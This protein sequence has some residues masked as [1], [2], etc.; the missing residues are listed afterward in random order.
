M[1]V[2]SELAKASSKTSLWLAEH[3]DLSK[4][5]A[6]LL[7]QTALFPPAIKP[8]PKYPYPYPWATVGHAVELRMD[9]A[10]GLNY[11]DTPAPYGIGGATRELGVHDAL[12]VLWREMRQ[13]RNTSRSNAWV[14]FYAGVFE[15]FF[16]GG[17]PVKWEKQHY[18]AW[19]HLATSPEWM[20]FRSDSHRRGA[21]TPMV[22]DHPCVLDLAELF[23]LNE[24]VVDD[25]IA[26]T[27]A[28]LSSRSWAEVMAQKGDL[29]ARPLFSGGKWINGADGDFIIKHRLYDVKTTID[30]ARLLPSGLAQLLC[31]VALDSENRYQIDEMALYFPR[32]HG[33]TAII[34]LE[35]VLKH[36]AF[37]T[38]AEMRRSIRTLLEPPLSP[39]IAARQ[40][41]LRLRKERLLRPSVG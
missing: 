31:Y 4:P 7:Q 37:R 18:K 28:T 35:E 17:V 1:S 6:I 30:P 2:T 41:A 23:P 32:Q 33:A 29:N 5:L 26:V 24:R 19:Q 3:F 36:S 20:K 13:E 40:E 12:D 34:S 8:A 39:E 21:P 11:A 22:R 9:Q 25:I 10:M 16:Y 15:G 27:D 14:L 38:P